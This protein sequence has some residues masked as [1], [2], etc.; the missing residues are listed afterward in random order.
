MTSSCR[1]LM[2]LK[3]PSMS[4]RSRAFF[5]FAKFAFSPIWMTRRSSSFPRTESLIRSF[6]SRLYCEK[7]LSLKNSHK[8]ELQKI[9]RPRLQVLAIRSVLSLFFCH[10]F[11]QRP[12][13]RHYFYLFYKSKIK[14]KCSSIVSS[15]LSACLPPFRRFFFF[16]IKPKFGMR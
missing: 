1:F 13:F 5:P 10:W 15:H 7:G 16:F 2:L 9:E 14:S 12:V 8:Q 4:I 11:S 6:A 3:A